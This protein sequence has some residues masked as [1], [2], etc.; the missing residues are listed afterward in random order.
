MNFVIDGMPPDADAI[1][2]E[3][4]QISARIK[5]IHRHDTIVTFILILL[6]SAALGA[7]VYWGT[8][9]VKYAAISASVFPIIGVIMSLTGLTTATGF[10]SAV[11]RMGELNYNLVALNPVSKESYNDIESLARK[12][13]QV[14]EY[15]N[16]VKNLGR[17]VVNG[18]LAMFWEW[19][20]STQAKTARKRAMLEKAKGE[21]A[22]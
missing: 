10:R 5:S 1:T 4:N 16:R 22:E 19:D 8:D 12:Y 6:T 13:K 9:N 20:S 14:E 2:E 21:V 3:R 11:V 18:E 7:A 17:D 15:I